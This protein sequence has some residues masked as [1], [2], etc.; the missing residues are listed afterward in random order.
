MDC[1]AL[2]KRYESLKSERSGIEGR[3]NEIEQ[4]IA[5]YRGKMFEKNSSDNSVEWNKYKLFDATA[6]NAAHTLAASVQGS[7]LSPA[8]RWFYLN[9]GD[10]ELAKDHEAKVWLEECQEIIYTQIQESNFNTE[11]SETLLDLATFHTA[12]ISQEYSNGRLVFHSIP[13]KELFFEMDHQDRPIAVFRVMEWTLA[14]IKAKFGDMIPDSLKA[15]VEN[16][17]M[18]M[19]RH[20][21]VFTV[22]KRHDDEFDPAMPLA[23]LARPWGFK[24]FLLDSAEQLGEEGGYFEMPISIVRWEKTS[25]SDYGHG[26][27]MVALPDIKMLNRLIELHIKAAEKVIDPVTIGR[28]RGILSDFDLSAGSHIVVRDPDDIKVLESGAK[29]DVSM[30]LIEQ[31]RSS[32]RQTFRVDELELKESPAMTATEANVRYEMMQRLLG[33]TMGRLQADL[34]DPLIKTTFMMLIRNDQLPE[35]P[36]SVFERRGQLQVQYIGALARSQKM[37]QIQSVQSLVQQAAGLAQVNEELLDIIDFDKMIRKQ[38][39]MMG[40]PTDILRSEGEVNKI[41]RQRQVVQAAQMAA[42]MRQQN[43]EAEMAE[44]QADMMQ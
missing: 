17:S 18:Q 43:A 29:I 15:K 24:Y 25:D 6:V 44:G 26:C 9:F 32:I 36:E 19:E 21:V 42:Q 34:M 11:V 4:Y 3:W 16:P 39:E 22:Y 33:N 5:P 8:I 14:K 30:A 12:G 2:K 41:R 20:T 7:L 1:K 27:S 10:K 28:Q 37:D 40:I 23:P 31:Y 13:M 38:A 35:V